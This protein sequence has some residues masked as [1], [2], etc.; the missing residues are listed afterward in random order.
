MELTLS[1]AWQASLSTDPPFIA[2]IAKMQITRY[3]R[4]KCNPVPGLPGFKQTLLQ[5]PWYPIQLY[6]YHGRNDGIPDGIPSLLQVRYGYTDLRP[7]YSSSL[8]AFWVLLFGRR[9]CSL[10]LVPSR[11]AHLFSFSSLSYG[12]VAHRN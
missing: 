2:R 9:G 1:L 12:P 8:A 5:V 7:G 11:F 10:A 4:E 3:L 6:R